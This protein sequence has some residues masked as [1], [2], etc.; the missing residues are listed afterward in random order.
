MLTN[1]LSV[2]QLA[3]DEALTLYPFRWSTAERMFFDL[4]EVLNLNRLYAANPNAVA[5]QVYAPST[6]SRSR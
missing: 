2:K 5:M 6:P 3:A 1:V 4:E